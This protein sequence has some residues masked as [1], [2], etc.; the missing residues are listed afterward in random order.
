MKAIKLMRCKTTCLYLL[1]MLVAISSCGGQKKE[2]NRS[3]IKK[4]SI[5]LPPGAIPIYYKTDS[6]I[7][8]CF[9]AVLNKSDTVVV[10]WDT[11]ASRMTIPNL[12]KN[13]LNKEDTIKLKIGSNEMN[14]KDVVRF[15][16]VFNSRL[17]ARKT[18][19]NILFTG[20]NLFK[21][22]IVEV[23]YK[24]RYI[25]MLENTNGL[26]SYDCIPFKIKNNKLEISLSVTIQGKVFQIKD[27]II[28]TGFDNTFIS[29]NRVLH[30]LNTKKSLPF[31]GFLGPDKDTIS[32]NILFANKI[33]AGNVSV[34]S[35]MI[36]ITK[37]GE[38]K[39]GNWTYTNLLGNGFLENF[40]VVFDFINHNLYLKPLE[41]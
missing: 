36:C 6:I 38:L 1:I 30:G 23:S 21:N 17:V 15:S 22:K 39:L 37:M 18:R 11:G 19:K 14:Y 41:S 33:K 3:S 26:M 2:V 29:D 16:D 12:Y 25:R 34:D 13:R 32:G 10:I 28:D 7:F 35:L 8:I 9:K 4:D 24:D 31:Q 20:W 40:S 27:A 5:S